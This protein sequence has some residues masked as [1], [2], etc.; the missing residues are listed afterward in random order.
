MPTTAVS[1]NAQ[2]DANQ[3]MEVNPARGSSGK[4]IYI[5]SGTTPPDVPQP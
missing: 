2:D 5:W 1:Q 4:Q 3:C